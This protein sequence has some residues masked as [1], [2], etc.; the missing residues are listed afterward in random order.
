MTYGTAD[1]SLSGRYVYIKGMNKKLPMGLVASV[2]ASVVLLLACAPER[3]REKPAPAPEVAGR[4]TVI[5]GDTIEI[6]GQR[7]RLAGI[8]APESRQSCG[9]RAETWP[10]G[11]RAAMALADRVGTRTVRCAQQGKD[12]YRRL[13]AVCRAG[14]EDLS[15]WMVEEG[16]AMA[17][18]RYSKSYVTAEDEARM[19]GRGIWQGPFIPPWEYRKR[20]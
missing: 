15:A 1:P 3:G 11:R 19:S 17:Y 7:I 9:P 2:S 14:G 12:R 13:I 18:R 5:D 16:W 10:C 8:D 20:G 6:S 4:A